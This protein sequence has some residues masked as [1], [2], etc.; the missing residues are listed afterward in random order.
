MTCDELKRLFPPWN[1]DSNEEKAERFETDSGGSRWFQIISGDT[2]RARE[3]HGHK[4]ATTLDNMGDV[5]GI[6]IE[7]KTNIRLGASDARQDGAAI[8]Y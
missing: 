6:T 8:G 2:R 3:A 4:F 7:E 1:T 5:H